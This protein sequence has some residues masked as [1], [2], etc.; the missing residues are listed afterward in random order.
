[1]L[2]LWDSDA[3]LPKQS[4]VVY[5]WNGYLENGS[6]RSLLGYVERHGERLKQ[7]YLS[8]THELGEQ[9]IHG[10]SL[11]DHLS[12][13]DGLSYWW[14]TVFVEKHYNTLPFVDVLRLF[15]LEEIL[16]QDKPQK[17]VLVSAN[18]GLHQ[19]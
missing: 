10:K 9:C 13:K 16:K 14:M 8:F 2:T 18:R 7:Q 3:T 1:M 5:S 17:F 12:F 4:G 15:A 19:Y 11:V 6:V